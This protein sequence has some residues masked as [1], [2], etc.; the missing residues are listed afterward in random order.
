MMVPRHLPTVLNVFLSSL[1]LMSLAVPARAQ[2]EAPAAAIEDTPSTN[3]IAGCLALSIA[4]RMAPMS[5][6]TPVAV[7]LCVART[8]L[9]S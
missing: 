3:S 4:L 1:A 8:A 5:E 2:Q 9:I 6:V 7:S